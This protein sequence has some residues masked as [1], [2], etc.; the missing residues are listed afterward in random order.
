M[1]ETKE[2][3]QL[4]LPALFDVRPVTNQG[5]LDLE[6]I[7]RVRQVLNLQNTETKGQAQSHG[8]VLKIA[9]KSRLVAK[10]VSKPKTVWKTETKVQRP[11]KERLSQTVLS[12]PSREEILAELE[13]V[14]RLDKILGAFSLAPDL[15]RYKNGRKRNPQIPIS[16][17][18]RDAQ[19]SHRPMPGINVG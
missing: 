2:H 13:Q 15:G 19:E 11:K 3:P 4:I 5:N 18:F 6:K 9:R 12:L 1:G 17:I 16:C 8:D 10:S 14:N 7:K